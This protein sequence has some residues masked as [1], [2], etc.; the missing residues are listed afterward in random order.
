MQ[1]VNP[2]YLYGLFAIAIP[3][4]IHLFNFRRFRKVY[5]TNVKFLKELKQQTQK[6]SQLRHLLILAA[7]I[8]ALAALVLAFAQPYIPA[9]ETKG[10]L[11]SRN[12]VSVFVDN[13]FSMEAIGSE[14]NIFEESKKKAQEIVSAYK[15]SDLFQ[16]LSC[17]FEGR[18]QRLVSRD[19][20]LTLLNEL[21]ISPTARSFDEIVRRQYDLLQTQGN[22]K[23]S[24]YII[25]DF[26]KSS[27]NKFSIQADSSISTF[28]IPLIPSTSA[29][30]YIDSCWFAQ[31]TQQAGKA[32]VL[33]ARIRNISTTDLEKIPLKLLINNQ[34]KAVASVDIKAGSYTEIEIPFTIH[35]TGAQQ[36]ILQV[37]DYPVTYDDKFFFSFDVLNSI[38]VLSINGSTENTY[39]QA[40]FA[41]DSAVKLTNVNEKMLDYSKIAIYNLII[42]NELPSLSSGLSQ[43]VKKFVINGGSILILPAENADLLSYNN[44]AASLSCPAYLK[45]DTA[46]TKV[47]RLSEESSLF[48]NVFEKNQGQK[49]I[50]NNTDLPTVSKHFPIIANSSMIS[51]PLMSMI[52]GRVFLYQTQSGNG[53]IF[54]L[55]VPLN[56]SFSDFPRQAVFVPVLY[57]LAIQSHIG[58]TLYG[59]I[60]DN[61]SIR[62]NIPPPGGDKVFKLKS[63]SGGPEVIPQ[64]QQS[65]SALQ[66]FVGNL[67]QVA[68]NYNLLHSGKSISSLAFNY[69]IN[70]SDLS[71]N[72][73]SELTDLIDKSGLSNFKILKTSQKP[74][75]EII[76]RMNSGT[77]LWKY[78]I[79][80]A[81][82]LLFTEVLL[83]RFR[84]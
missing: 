43:E 19:E 27:F 63:A 64:V 3:I 50:N 14:G 82:L 28:L 35:Q 29:N 58:H 23:R 79:W 44:F 24:A 16:L 68:D 49:A 31:P 52:N 70:E 54:Q 78:L 20:F 8:L 32:S 6:Q 10:S 75:N 34:Q 80:L 17:D 4:I 53:Q 57:N 13:S 59:F 46:N 37:T 40:L 25:S 12:I 61:K 33:T 21:K 56:T 74:L 65:G 84:K 26:Q 55:A 22:G 51:M 76:S 66:L 15:T 38:D 2:T 77:Q 1:F 81:L 7:R 71:C 30:I 62:M 5:F 83:I 48:R 60:G 41:Q 67:I 39:L 45:V 72:S 11:A 47:S 73:I 42:L 36:G 9:A 18:H 69:N